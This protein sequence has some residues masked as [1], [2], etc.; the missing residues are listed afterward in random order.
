MRL[1]LTAGEALLSQA[2][3]DVGWVL[4]VSLPGKRSSWTFAR[5]LA[6]GLLLD[7]ECSLGCCLL[8]P[9]QRM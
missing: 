6:R 2:K 7:C 4:G 8:P 9:L 5:V 3:L 1:P